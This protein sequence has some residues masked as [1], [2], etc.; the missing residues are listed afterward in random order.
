MMTAGL[1]GEGGGERRRS[2]ATVRGDT[3]EE[4]GRRWRG[5]N[6]WLGLA[7]LRGGPSPCPARGGG[8][9]PRVSRSLRHAAATAALRRGLAGVAVRVGKERGRAGSPPRKK[10][11][12]GKPAVTW[13]WRA[14]ALALMQRRGITDMHT[15]TLIHCYNAKRLFL[16]YSLHKYEPVR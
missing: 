11:E 7:S 13:W 10:R 1:G 12:E 9:G 3:D 8:R 15:R 14:C 5:K 6:Q 2:A 16:L 4:E